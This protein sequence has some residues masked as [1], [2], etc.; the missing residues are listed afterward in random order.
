MTTTS[1]T[2]GAHG[3][4][5]RPANRTA[6]RKAICG[7]ARTAAPATPPSWA[8][9][10]G[11]RGE[12]H[13]EADEIFAATGWP[14]QQLQIF[15]RLESLE[16]PGTGDRVSRSSRVRWPCRPPAAAAGWPWPRRL[17]SSPASASGSC[18]N[19]GASRRC[20]TGSPAP[21][22]PRDARR[23]ETA[24][25]HPAD[26]RRRRRGVPLA[27]NHLFAGRESRE[28]LQYL[29]R[30]HPRRPRFDPR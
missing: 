26:C 27:G 21:D 17:A 6:L 9:S 16:H 10:D 1:P 12:A 14:T 22:R 4:G 11:M 25:D 18:S 20:T 19:S 13:A 28:S 2:C 24:P 7:S 30:D 23:C 5:R 3:G 29:E 15:R 8:G